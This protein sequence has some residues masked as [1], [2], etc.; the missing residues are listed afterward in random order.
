MVLKVFS[1][2]DAKA[3]AFM[4]P[5]MYST[6]GQAIRVFADSINDSNCVLSKHP[7]DYTLFEIATF[8][9]ELGVYVSLDVKV[10]LGLALEF[11]NKSD[12]S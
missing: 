5:F 2:Y 11:L 6:K 7:E 1:V 9:E 4:P 12:G 3:E 8:D 10:S